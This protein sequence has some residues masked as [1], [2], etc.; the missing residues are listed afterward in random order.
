MRQE[1]DYDSDDASSMVSMDRSEAASDSF[2]D[3][4]TQGEGDEEA[5]DEAVEELTEKR[6]ILCCW[7][8]DLHPD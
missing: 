3:T 5:I 8:L 7:V 1:D 2:Y 6:C 4:Y